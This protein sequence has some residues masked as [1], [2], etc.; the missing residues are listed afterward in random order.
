MGI[1]S[2]KHRDCLLLR[3]IDVARPVITGRVRPA[4]ESREDADAT[5]GMD[6]ETMA[7]KV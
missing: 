2:G 3:V 4:R 1:E 5:A 7:P 6:F